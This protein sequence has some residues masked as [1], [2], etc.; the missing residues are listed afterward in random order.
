MRHLIFGPSSVPNKPQTV[1]LKSGFVFVKMVHCMVKKVMACSRAVGITEV[2]TF[3][4]NIFVSCI[5]DEL[6]AK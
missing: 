1:Q 5:F 3:V 2:L 4:I 6:P